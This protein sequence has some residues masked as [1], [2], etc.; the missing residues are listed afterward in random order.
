MLTPEDRHW[1]RVETF[2][3]DECANKV[4]ERNNLTGK[5][6]L[7]LDYAL[8]VTCRD[9]LI[10]FQKVAFF[11]TSHV[12]VIRDSVLMWRLLSDGMLSPGGIQLIIGCLQ[13]DCLAAS[14]GL[15]HPAVRWSLSSYTHDVF[16]E[17]SVLVCIQSWHFTPL[18][19]C[20]CRSFKSTILASS[21]V[22]RNLVEGTNQDSLSH[23]EQVSAENMMRF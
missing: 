7:S 17:V 3:A 6:G 15:I 14:F 18:L 23:E 20:F 2:H 19:A 4:S 9:Q 8:S 10:Y 21:H 13:A 16:E 12:Y 5:G 1:A 11:S 22:V